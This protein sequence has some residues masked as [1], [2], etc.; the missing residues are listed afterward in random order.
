MTVA[1]APFKPYPLLSRLPN[2]N[3]EFVTL[4]V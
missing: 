1:K 3:T 4:V 2:Y